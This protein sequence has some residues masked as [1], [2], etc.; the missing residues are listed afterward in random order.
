[1][2]EITISQSDL[3]DA[4]NFLVQFMT[5][6]V[7]EASYEKG[8]AT[9]DILIRGFTYLYA[10]IRGEIDRV[11]AKQSLE[12][13]QSEL[14]DSSDVAQAVDEI[15]S[16]FFV[17][18]RG[19]QQARVTARFHFTARRAYT[20]PLASKFWRTNSL[21]FQ[22]DSD[23]DPLVIP[24]SSLFPVFDS[25]GILVDYIVEIG[26]KASSIGVGYNIE[27]GTFVKAQVAG[28]LP[29]LSYIENRERGSSGKDVESSEDL[30]AR[31]NTAISVRNLVN[32]RSCDVVLQEQFPEI[33]S[34]LTIG[35]G[36]PEMIRDL[37]TEIAP[38]LSIHTGGTYDTY[39][40]LPLYQTEENGTIGGYFSRPDGIACVFRDP[41][42]TQPVLGGD[43]GQPFTSFIPAITPGD[44]LYL[45]DGVIDTPRGFQ[46]TR[47]S[48]H[49]L[50]VSEFTPFPE[51]SD[52]LATNAVIYSV[53]NLSPGFDNKIASRTATVS[54]D[55][56][57]STIPFGTSRKIQSPGIIV[58][59]GKPVQDIVRVELTDPDGTMSSF[60]DSGTGTV[61]FYGHTNDVPISPPSAQYTQYQVQVYN[62]KHAQSMRQVLVINVGWQTN[63]SWAD[64]KNL[65]VIYQ[66]PTQFTAV[67]TFASS[68]DNRVLAADHLIRARHPVWIE[69]TVEYRGKLNSAVVLDETSAS[70]T[71]AAYINAFDPTDDLDTSDIATQLR[72]SYPDSIGAVYPLTVQYK[73]LAPDGQIVVFETTDIIS[74]SMDASHPGVTL[75]NG[76][77]IVPPP[78]FVARGI[79]SIDSA[80]TLRDWFYYLGV[81]DRTVVYRTN[82]DAILFVPKG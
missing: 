7:P 3:D 27:P 16:N 71:L 20:I 46:I 77:E 75:I 36:E 66:T 55:P 28:G 78:E 61:V 67:H 47:V 43:L 38:R 63:A 37:R 59:S 76:S 29:F 9:R 81:S 18:R 30:I 41:H 44:I 51:A 49:E 54:S 11:T 50:E 68:R 24:E 79:S 42:L 34:T 56:A 52:E 31:A 10:Y 2:T 35:M 53:G 26:L 13:I 25:R 32:N 22:I 12:R 70:E 48:D 19:G 4:E 72:V 17:T 40:D 57:K 80:E 8:S 69:M 82:K 60:I 23:V 39:V 65:R 45:W 21:A 64:G 15:L 74:I 1:M 58:L 6:R 5:E 73:L 14:T 62:H 33:K